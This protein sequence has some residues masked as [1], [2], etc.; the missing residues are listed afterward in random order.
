[1]FRLAW[2]YNTSSKSGTVLTLCLPKKDLLGTDYSRSLA[3]PM[4]SFPAFLYRRV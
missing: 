3:H 1:M 2:T 4:S